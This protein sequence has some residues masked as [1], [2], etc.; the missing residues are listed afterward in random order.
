LVAAWWCA[1][2]QPHVLKNI[3]VYREAGRYGGWPAN[4]GIWVWG[5]E[6]LVGFSAAWFQLKTPDLHQYDSTRPEEPRL[7]RSLDGGETWTIEAPPSLLPPEQGGRA[8]T[9]L[10]K[11]MNFEDPGFAMALNFGDKDRGPSRLWYS[12]DRG[13]S[14]RGP[15]SFPQFGQ[16]GIAARTDYIV[17]GARD[18][19]VFVTAAKQDGTEGRALCVKTEDGGLSWKMVSF[20]GGEPSGF[21]IQ[22]SSVRLAER[23]LLTATR[24]KIDE[25]TTA[26]EVFRSRDNGGS[27]QP[28]G[29]PAVWRGEFNGN[30]PSLI[31]LKDGRLCLSYG[32]RTPP[33]R[34]CARL[35]ADG[36]RTWSG[37]I[38][39]R[40]D[41]AMWD[42][43]YVRSAERADGKV[44]TVYYFPERPHTERVIAATIW[45]P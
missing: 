34:I 35:S 3:T 12:V 13:K 31:R 28:A 26:I 1:A 27:W 5:N 18:A 14:W 39:L 6:I 21:S 33:Y 30:P 29:R 16:P 23:E 9:R 41:G 10:D 8:A 42:L 17:N 40:N 37:E 20:I 24:V 7:A 43:G 22:P 2:A 45:E 15:Y 38:V 4:H 36:G 25:N 32:V 19:F 11:S 44:V